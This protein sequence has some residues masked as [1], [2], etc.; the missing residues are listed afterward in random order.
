MRVLEEYSE[1]KPIILS[2]DEEDEI[3]IGC[4]AKY[5]ANNFDYDNSLEFDTTKC[6]GQYKKP[7]LIKNFVNITP[8]FVSLT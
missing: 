5:I 8:H 2:T 6:D 7:R 4:V 3:S 1:N